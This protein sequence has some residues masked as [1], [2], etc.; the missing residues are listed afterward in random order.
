METSAPRPVH[1]FCSPVVV[2][3]PDVGWVKWRLERSDRLP[4]RCIAGCASSSQWS[5]PQRSHCKGWLQRPCSIALPIR[6]LTPTSTR[7]STST[8]TSTLAAFQTMRYTIIMAAS[9]SQIAGMLDHTTRRTTHRLLRQSAA[10][11]RHVAQAQPS[12]HRQ[13]NWA[14]SLRLGQ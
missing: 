10:P 3:T 8:T 11:V 13:C 12:L 6:W 4:R 9:M 5:S 1:E 7:T 14:L 2:G